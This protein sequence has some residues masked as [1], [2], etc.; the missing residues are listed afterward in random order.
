MGSQVMSWEVAVRQNINRCS[1]LTTHACTYAD[2]TLNSPSCI[3]HI[4]HLSV[5]VYVWICMIT[6][7]LNARSCLWAP[8][9]EAAISSQHE[10]QS[11]AMPPSVPSVNKWFHPSGPL[12]SSFTWVTHDCSVS[13]RPFAVYKSCLSLCVH[14]NERK[15]WIQS[16]L[17]RNTLVTTCNIWFTL[18]Q[19][20]REEEWELQYSEAFT[21]I[22]HNCIGWRTLRW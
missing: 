14:S 9:G 17:N 18:Q 13:M 12:H 3:N 10:V 5:R 19:R 8:W 15:V 22:K 6:C 1:P 7:G 21:S 20:E 11:K 2:G 4:Q 16:Y